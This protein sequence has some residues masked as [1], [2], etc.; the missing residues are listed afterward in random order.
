MWHE[1]TPLLNI[2]KKVKCR[3]VPNILE[4]TERNMITESPF[5]LPLSLLSNINCDM[6]LQKRSKNKTRGYFDSHMIYTHP[7]D[8]Q[9]CNNDNET[10]PM[11]SST[12]LFYGPL[13]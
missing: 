12:I 7:R 5:L 4:P 6:A 8:N 11:Q 3:R 13:G 2:L 1:K 10:A 9:F